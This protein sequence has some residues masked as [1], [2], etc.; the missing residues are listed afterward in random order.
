[1]VSALLARN[2]SMGGGELRFLG[3]ITSP[4]G[5]VCAEDEQRLGSGISDN[6]NDGA[7]PRAVE[8]TTAEVHTRGCAV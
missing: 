1:M 7:S 2:G 3:S 5:T 6:S 4:D 8:K